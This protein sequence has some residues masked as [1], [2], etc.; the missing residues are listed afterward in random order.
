MDLHTPPQP[1]PQNPE[2]IPDRPSL[3]FPLILGG[4]ILMLSFG[5]AG[6]FLGISSGNAQ[7]FPSPTAPQGISC[8]MEAKLCPDGSA[9]GRVPPDCEYAPCPKTNPTPG[10][11]ACVNHLGQPQDEQACQGIPAEARTCNAD[12]DCMATCGHGCLSK[13]WKSPTSLMDCMAMPMY[14]CG[15]TVNTCLPKTGKKECGGWDSSGEVVCTCSGTLIKPTCAPGA[16]CDSA[17]YTCEG[18]CG[19]CCYKGIAENPEYP[20]CD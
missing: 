1:L 13:S 17:V 14:E 2:K 5:A 3:P 7:P 11:S 16:V 20:K 9:V 8:T 6:Y 4:I 18:E 12:S 19:S 15:C 10:S